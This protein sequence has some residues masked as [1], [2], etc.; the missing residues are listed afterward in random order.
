MMLFKLAGARARLTACVTCFW[1][2]W[3][4]KPI[5]TKCPQP[6]E[7]GVVIWA[8]CTTMITGFILGVPHYVEHNLSFYDS[9][10]NGEQEPWK[11]ANSWHSWPIPNG[12]GSKA[13]GSPCPTKR[14]GTAVRTTRCRPWSVV[15]VA[16]NCQMCGS[17]LPGL[18]EFWYVYFID[19]YRCH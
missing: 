14:L 12:V 3:C 13:Y 18:Y 7:M 2:R 10:N 4:G 17:D 16:E 9:W 11:P 5:V 1:W 15:S 6:P 19:L 8:I